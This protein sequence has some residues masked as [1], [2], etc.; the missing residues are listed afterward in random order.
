[1]AGIYG[2]FLAYFSELFQDVEFFEQ[3]PD[4]GAGYKERKTIGVYPVIIQA[5]VGS[6][7]AG[8]AGR[9][10]AHHTWRSLDVINNAV[11]WCDSDTPM[12]IGWFLYH[13]I[14]NRVYRVASDLEYNREGGFTCWGITKLTGDTGDM[15]GRL[16]IYEGHL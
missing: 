9:L 10:S 4:I 16:P 8:P 6:S 5:D 13:P 7:I 2:S 3:E 1:M 12:K 14:D 11:M 15:K